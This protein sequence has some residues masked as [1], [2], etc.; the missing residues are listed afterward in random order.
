MAKK[1][2]VGFFQTLPE[3]LLDVMTRGQLF[4]VV[5]HYEIGVCVTKEGD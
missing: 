5:A 4:E 3:D 1:P 2:G